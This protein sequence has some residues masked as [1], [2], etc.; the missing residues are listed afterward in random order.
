MV[1]AAEIH[2][3]THF[4]AWK[5]SCIRVCIHTLASASQLQGLEDSNILLEYED[6]WSFQA[7][8]HNRPETG[9]LD[10]F[11]QPFSNSLICI[12]CEPVIERI[13]SPS[14]ARLE[15]K[16]HR[17]SFTLV[18]SLDVY[19][20][21]TNRSNCSI[22]S[23]DRSRL[24]KDSKSIKYVIITGQN[25]FKHHSLV[26]LQTVQTCSIMFEHGSIVTM[27]HVCVLTCY[28]LVGLVCFSSNLFSPYGNVYSV[29]QGRLGYI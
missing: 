12:V 10:S 16:N 8:S 4:Y 9:G 20:W 29:Q 6:V 26:Y 18:Y 24:S 1:V 7:P 2:T 25:T 15:C 11:P 27:N 21:Q 5:S 13:L 19:S 17:K 3:A 14:G 23:C 22:P 28:T